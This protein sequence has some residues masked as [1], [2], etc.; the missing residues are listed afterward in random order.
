MEC[1][2]L[3]KSYGPECELFRGATFRVRKGEFVVLSGASGSGK[4][5]L[6]RVLLAVERPDAGQVLFHGHNIHDISPRRLSPIRQKMGIVLQQG[7]LVPQWTLFDNVAIPL[8]VAGKDRWLIRKKVLKTLESLNLHHKANLQCK[9]LGAAEHRLVEIAR[10]AVNNPL[11]LIADEPLHCLG[12][13]DRSR[14]MALFRE[15]SVGGST[16][17]VLSGEHP[18]SG[19]MMEM[20]WLQISNHRFEE[21]WAA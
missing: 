11:L 4:S 7:K 20:R 15:L 19:N 18:E 14:V 8:V 6:M 1:I 17:L 10:A 16:L 21:T 13:T 12:P 3:S 5:T 2:Q 9:G